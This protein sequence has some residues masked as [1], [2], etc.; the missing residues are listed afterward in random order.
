MSIVSTTQ[1]QIVAERLNWY[2]KFTSYRDLFEAFYET[3]TIGRCKGHAK[4]FEYIAVYRGN[5][6]FVHFWYI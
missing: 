3:Q 2:S 6:F 4:E 5:F 1:K